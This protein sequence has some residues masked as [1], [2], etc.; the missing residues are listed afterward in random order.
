MKECS[1]IFF[2]SLNCKTFCEPEVTLNESVQTKKNVRYGWYDYI[3][4]A[5]NGG[6]Y[7]LDKDILTPSLTKNLFAIFLIDFD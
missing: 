7:S 2:N 3:S 1:E 4:S 5:M 6:A